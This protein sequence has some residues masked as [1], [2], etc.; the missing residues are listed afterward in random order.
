MTRRRLSGTERRAQLLD[1]ARD[2]VADGGYP[3]LTIEQVASRSGVTRTVVYQQFTDL[4][5]LTTALL[6]RESAIAF[7]GMSTVDRPGLDPEQLGIGILAYLHA[8]PTSWRIILRPPDGAPPQVRER[9]ELGRRYARKVAA[10]PLSV[11]AGVDIDPDG[12]TVR[13]LLSAIEELARVHL[14]DPVAHPDEEVLTHLRSLVAW[15][16]NVLM[17]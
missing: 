4:S 6:D 11:A 3:A 5:G 9:I 12:T 2:I 14:E 10:R 8:A 1:A 7:A 17:V 16:V 15:A 13:I